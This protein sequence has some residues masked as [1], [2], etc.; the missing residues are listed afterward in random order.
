MPS[1]TSSARLRPGTHSVTAAPSTSSGMPGALGGQHVEQPGAA[2][3]LEAAGAQRADHHLAGPGG[4]GRVVAADR[5]SAASRRSTVTADVALQHGVLGPPELG[6]GRGVRPDPGAQPVAAGEQGAGRG[7]RRAAGRRRGAVGPARRA[8]RGGPWAA[9][10]A[11]GPGRGPA[12]GL[13]PAGAAEP[14]ER[15]PHRSL[16]SSSPAR[17]ATPLAAAPPIPPSRAYVSGHPYAEVSAGR[18]AVRDGTRM[19]SFPAPRAAS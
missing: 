7:H 18:R 17:T 8:G 4:A 19:G 2:V 6:A 14:A 9:V 13:G 11:A 5:V 1:A 15:S 10:R 12:A 16:R 3:V